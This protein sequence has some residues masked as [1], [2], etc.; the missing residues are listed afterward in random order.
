MNHKT[1]HHSLTRREFVKAAGAATI[2]VGLSSLRGASQGASALPEPNATQLPR[3]RGFNLLEKFTKRS[4]GNGPFR[5]T[6]FAW[7]ADWGFNF[8]RLPMSYLCWTDPSVW[9]KLREEELKHIDGAVELGGKYGVHVNMNFHRAPGYCVNPP[10]EPLDLWKDEK[11]LDACAFHWAQFAKRYKGIPNSRVSFDLLNEPG[12]IPEDTYTRVVRRLVEAIRAEDPNRLIIADGLRWGN[13]PVPSLADLKIAQS[14][15]G[16]QPSRISHYKA[17][18][19]RGSDQWPE[20]TWPLRIN[21]RDVWDKERLRKEQ[22]RPWQQLQQKGVG[23][24]VGEW[25]AYQHTPHSVVMAWMGD[26]LELWKEAGW[27]WA[28]W[29]FRGSFGILD[30]NRTDAHY[31]DFHGHKLDR[32]MLELIQGI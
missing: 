11:A 24:H 5:E 1:A 32:A 19:M 9:L 29:N 16:Y 18:W 8:V 13:K 10:K 22:I 28:M 14:T 3:W 2:A 17:S 23:V 26:Y 25:G 31:E 7:I 15:R 6:D 30:S 20:P 4:E 21:E 27:G 12:D